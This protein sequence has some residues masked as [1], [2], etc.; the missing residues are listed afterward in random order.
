MPV[1]SGEFPLR[2]LDEGVDLGDV[3]IVETKYNELKGRHIESTAALEAWLLDW[4]E[5]D[6]WLD[7]EESVRH[8]EMTCH[9]DDAQ[10]EKRYLSFI[11][12][13]GEPAKAWS[14]NLD[15][16]FLDSPHRARLD[17]G[18]YGIVIRQIENRVAIFREEN[19]PLETQDE[20]LRQAYQ[21]IVGGMTVHYDG[22][23][24]T[25]QELARYLENPDRAVRQETWEKS[26]VV[27][28][29]ARDEIENIYDEMVR[30]R[31][32]IGTNAGF[33]NYRDYAFRALERFDYG[34]ADCERF[35]DS[36][37]RVVAPAAM[38]LAR[39]RREK[40]GLSSLRPWDMAVDPQ[41]RT[42]LTP[43]KNAEQLLAGCGK[44]FAKLDAGLSEQFEQMRRTGLLDLESRKGKAPGGYMME[45]KGRRLPFIFM[46]AVGTHDDVQTLL[47]ECG[48]AFHALAARN[49]NLTPLREAPIEFAEVASMG[50]ELF[51]GEHLSCLYEKPERDRAWGD[52]LEGIV[53]FFPYMATIDMLQHWAYTHPTHTRDERRSAWLG[54]VKRFAHWID[55]SGREEVVAHSW[56]RKGHPFTVPFYYVEYGI[57]QLGA[58]GVW[59]ASLADR[60]GAVRNY[61]KALSLGGSRPLPELFRAAGTRFDFSAEAIGPAIRSAMGE[62]H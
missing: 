31:H 17:A 43:F 13:V 53:N 16:K 25:M 8:V 46:N 5:L 62:I 19:L 51:A 37:E 41:G 57:A 34:P 44:I 59:T 39:R 2:F 3:D 49:E 6:A 24:Q 14:N 35:A 48:H 28:S 56:H 11:E 32:L 4:A 10:R 27:W 61:R 60:A 55:Y 12:E 42:P 7:E 20:K 54:L 45:F 52:H 50:M 33:G 47:H 18:R 23:E 9:T 21:K 40:L 26:A 15:R 58:L 29:A 1:T 22:R 38:E 30:V 36:I